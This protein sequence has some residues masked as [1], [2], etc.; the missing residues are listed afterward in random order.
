MLEHERERGLNS[1]SPSAEE[2]TS[3]CPSLRGSISELF[4]PH[5]P[6]NVS[7]AEIFVLNNYSSNLSNTSFGSARPRATSAIFAIEDGIGQA[8]W[9]LERSAIWKIGF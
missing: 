1:E 2:E 4:S 6:Q 7:Y 5:R 3:W 8:V 9:H